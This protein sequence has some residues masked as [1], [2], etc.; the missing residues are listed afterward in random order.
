MLKAGFSRLEITPPPGTCLAG[1]FGPRYAAGAADPLWVRALALDD[2]ER[3][4]LLLTFDLICLS[5]P[6]AR[7]I[8]AGV[9]RQGLPDAAVHLCASHTHTGPATVALLGCTEEQAYRDFL[10]KQTLAA[11][12][13]ALAALG[14][15]RL[16]VGTGR[17]TGI[18]FNRRFWMQDGRVHTNPG[19]RNPAIV[20]PAGPVDEQVIVLLV[21]GKQGDVVVGNFALHLDTVGGSKVSAD[22]PYWTGRTLAAA[23]PR[24][25]EFIFANGA[26]GDINHLDVTAEQRAPTRS[27]GEKL[28]EAMLA[29]LARRRAVRPRLAFAA[30]GVVLRRRQLLPAELREAARVAAA[31]PTDSYQV[32]HVYARERLAL[33]ALPRTLRA[34]VGAV[35]LGTRLR[36]VFLPGECFVE[37]GLTIKAALGGITAVVG[38]ADGSVGYVPTARA[39]QEGGYEVQAARSSQLAPGSGE[40][41]VAAALALARGL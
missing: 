21:E 34:R 38:N 1:Y 19:L 16:S 6:Q 4:G 12:A 36:L 25:L 26:F 18:A 28:G 23:W 8:R 7:A 39:Y 11:A 33:A 29:A 14:P 5:G 41:L 31:A 40:R 17:G 24:P 10:I 3:R 13:Q 30:G 20:R 37:H 22:Y 15:C 35:A 2:G 27:I 32:E 9:R